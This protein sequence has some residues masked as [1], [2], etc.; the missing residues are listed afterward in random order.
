MS[1]ARVVVADPDDGGSTA[2]DAICGLFII[3][4]GCGPHQPNN[5]KD[6]RD[7]DNAFPLMLCTVNLSLLRVRRVK[8][9]GKR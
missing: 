2:D 6:F 3:C 1:R 8:K 7:S 9:I 5:P 4:A